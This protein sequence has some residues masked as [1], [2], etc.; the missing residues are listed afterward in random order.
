M[1]NATRQV[2]AVS[3]PLPVQIPESACGIAPSSFDKLRMRALVEGFILTLG[4]LI[5]SLS[6]EKGEDKSPS[7]RFPKGARKRSRL[8]PLA[9][10]RKSGGP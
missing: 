10:L 2:M 7:Q 5:P 9:R 4:H 6:R 8:R 3:S 1:C